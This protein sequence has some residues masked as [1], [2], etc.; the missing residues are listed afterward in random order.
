MNDN[1][2]INKQIALKYPNLSRRQ[3][4]GSLAVATSSVALGGCVSGGILSAGDAPSKKTIFDQ[5][6]DSSKE[7]K[8]LI[9]GGFLYTSDRNNKAIENS[10]ILITGNKI[11]KIGSSLEVEPE[12]DSSIDARGKMVLPGFVNPHWHESFVEGPDRMK[13]DDSD[14]AKMPFSDGGNIEAL[15][16]YFGV[17]ADVGE[18]FTEQEAAAIARWSMWTQLRSGTTALGDIGSLNSTDAMANAAIS[19]GMRIRVS[20]WGSD[21]MIPNGASKF[22]RIA[23]T[24]KQANDWELL[25]Q[26]WDNHS[27]GLVGGM[28]SV[29]AGFGSSDEQLKSLGEIA[30]RYNSPY[31]AHLAPLK[32]EAKALQK[33]FG[34]SSIG[35]FD[36]FG[37]LTENLLAVHTAYATEMEYQ[38]ILKNKVNVVYSPANYGLLGETTVSET[39]MMGR[40]IRDGAPVS[41]STDGNISYTGGMPEAMRY[42]Y[43]GNNEAHNDNTTVSPTMALRTGTQN[44]ATALGW[45]DKIGS[46][47]T[48][49]EAD[50]VIVDIDDWRYRLITHPLSIFLIAG[51]SKDVDTVIVA[52]KVL[53]KEGKSTTIDENKMFNE[54]AVAVESARKRIFS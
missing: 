19:L 28:P 41:C 20:R 7:K 32:N 43:L 14:L 6:I 45:G 35:R 12:H 29:L 22:K 53:I 47:E 23:D 30:N 18:K 25:M 42:T 17:I 36:K 4:I 24:D 31:A 3:F 48:G 1:T 52:G 37:L 39:G 46:I 49:K 54:Y 5:S 33:V 38:Q 9:R 11:T 44:G 34:H 21:I 50:L 8:T 26:K 15:G 10:W 13:P 51:G 2:K 40:L 16:Q 27:S